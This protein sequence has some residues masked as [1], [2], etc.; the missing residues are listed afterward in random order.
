MSLSF[1]ILPLMVGLSGEQTQRIYP[2]L[3]RE[4]HRTRDAVRLEHRRDH[5]NDGST[6]AGGTLGLA[7]L[8]DGFDQVSDRSNMPAFVGAVGARLRFV[9]ARGGDLL[10]LRTAAPWGPTAVT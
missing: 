8:F 10:P 7:I 1:R 3:Q 5:F 6:V 9:D 4:F 2:S